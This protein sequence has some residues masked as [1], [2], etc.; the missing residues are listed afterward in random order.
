[1]PKPSFTSDDFTGALLSLLPRGR[2]WPK[3]LVSIQ[4]QSISCFAPMFERVSDK[5]VDLLADVFPGSTTDL[6]AEWE[7]T[8]GLPDSCTIAASQ[9]LAERQQAVA[10]KIS[11]SGGPQRSYYI[12]LASRLG[13]TATIDEFQFTTVDNASVGDFLYGD[14]W[15]WGWIAAVSPDDFGT[16]KAAML[17]CRLQQERP[18]YT[19][20]VVGF[21]KEIVDGIFSKVDQLFNAIHYVVPTAVAGIEDL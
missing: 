18:E 4:A 6:L 5:A 14:G 3:E 19:D 12:E 7:L 11:A 2:V 8:L 9:T 21:G 1:M 10:D 17:S 13:V 20:V 15:P 16:E